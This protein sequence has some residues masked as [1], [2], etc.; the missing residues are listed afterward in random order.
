MNETAMCDEEI[1]PF[2]RQRLQ[3]QHASDSLLLLEEFP[4]YGGDVR[5]DIVALNGSLHGYEIKSAK[6]KLGRLATQVEA[7]NAVFDRASIVAS[8]RHLEAVSSMIPD[9]WEILAIQ[10]VGGGVCFKSRQ[11]GRL[12]PKREG[13]ALVALLW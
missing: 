9:W 2:L 13:N 6:D 12:N 11:R 8:E 5:A 1:R 3:Q 4:I 7:Y 10:C